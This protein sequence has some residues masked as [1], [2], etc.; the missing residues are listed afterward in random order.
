MLVAAAL[1]PAPARAKAALERRAIRAITLSYQVPIP[2][3]YLAATE[4][5]P[6]IRRRQFPQIYPP[7]E[8]LPDLLTL[9]SYDLRLFSESNRSRRFVYFSTTIWNRGPGILEL[10]GAQ[11]QGRETLLVTQ[12]I[13]REDGSQAVYAAGDFEYEPEHGHWHWEN[14]SRYEIWSLTPD[15][16]LDD[17]L[18]FND[19]VGFCL[20]DV[21]VYRA[22]PAHIRLPEGQA[23]VADLEYDSCFWTRQGLS[24]GW[25]DT[26]RSNVPGQ[27]VEITRLEDG[28]YALVSTVDPDGMLRETD[29]WNNTSITYFALQG[30]RIEVVE[31]NPGVST[32]G[33][34]VQ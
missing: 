18:A 2:A 3:A 12:H 4:I 1:Y 9:P 31:I 22:N 28:L 27:F 13:L 11:I 8:L 5:E 7:V 23:Q 16:Q 32:P 25:M 33:Q 26:Y 15:L 10:R 19:K 29:D 14:F 17:R 30:D 34:A 21:R 6:E 24:T 20:R